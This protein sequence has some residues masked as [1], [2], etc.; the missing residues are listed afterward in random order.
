MIQYKL[1][2][3]GIDSHI[4]GVVSDARDFFVD[5][6]VTL[7]TPRNAKGNEVPVVFVVGCEDIYAKTS[8]SQQRQARNFM[9][10][11]ITRSKGWVYL[12]AVGRVKG[13]FFEEMKKIQKNMPNM[14]F[15]YPADDKLKELSKIDFLTNNPGAKLLDENVT[16]IKHAISSGK[17]ELLKQLFDLDPELKSSLLKILEG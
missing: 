2:N 6:R 10:I 9:F 5:N 11:S 13:V 16:K 1:H 8:M 12:S 14:R 15:I 7:T 3:Y 4:P 17:E